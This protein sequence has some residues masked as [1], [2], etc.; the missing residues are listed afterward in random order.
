VIA[1]VVM[2]GLRAVL[3]ANSDGDHGCERAA[4]GIVKKNVAP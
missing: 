2:F 4:S 1:F 3:G